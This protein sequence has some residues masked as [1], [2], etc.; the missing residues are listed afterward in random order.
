[1]KLETSIINEY[2]YLALA[3]NFT[4]NR[5]TCTISYRVLIIPQRNY[6]D[7]DLNKSAYLSYISKFI[8]K[9]PIT[10]L[11]LPALIALP[12]D[13]NISPAMTI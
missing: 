12:N 11:L 5:G 7:E 1:M 13:P 6:K 4:V 10:K 8:A 3:G 2:K 9:F